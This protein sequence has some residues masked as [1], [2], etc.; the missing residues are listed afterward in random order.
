MVDSGPTRKTAEG[1]GRTSSASSRKT[2]S[3]SRPRPLPQSE[4]C[5]LRTR[6]KNHSKLGII[7][8]VLACSFFI[9][10]TVKN[11]RFSQLPLLLNTDCKY[12]W[13]FVNTPSILVNMLSKCLFSSM[14][15]FFSPFSEPASIHTT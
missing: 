12:H 3:R 1:G 7:Y 2:S 5:K 10:L 8:H 9:P 6:K 13:T 15:D 4:K 11:K 14:L